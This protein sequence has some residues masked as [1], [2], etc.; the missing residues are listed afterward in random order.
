MTSMD[1][2]TSPFLLLPKMA[3]ETLC[4]GEG[5]RSSAGKTNPLLCMKILKWIESMFYSQAN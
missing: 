3:H 1:F 2:Q 5:K 4:L